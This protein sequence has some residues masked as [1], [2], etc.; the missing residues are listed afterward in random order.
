MHRLPTGGAGHADPQHFVQ[1]SASKDDTEHSQKANLLVL[2]PVP[3]LCLFVSPFA[4]NNAK[5]LTLQLAIS[6]IGDMLH[7]RVWR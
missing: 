1:G 7:W 5:Y 6:P 2:H 3:G 4:T